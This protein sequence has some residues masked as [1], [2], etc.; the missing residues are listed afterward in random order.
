M[1][2]LRPPVFFEAGPLWQCT[3]L[4]ILLLRDHWK[5]AWSNPATIFYSHLRVSLQCQISK[6]KAN[7]IDSQWITNLYLPKLAKSPHMFTSWTSSSPSSPSWHSSFGRRTCPQVS[8]W[9][10]SY[11]S[12]WKRGNHR[13][14]KVSSS[15][16]WERRDGGIG[17]CHAIMPCCGAL[18][19]RTTRICDGWCASRCRLARTHG[20]MKRLVRKC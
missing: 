15:F 8:S 13:E 6:V 17:H 18:R 4:M 9:L 10:C 5:W 14:L 2:F 1:E 12:S 3:F 16:H 19:N 11:S 20:T 7:P